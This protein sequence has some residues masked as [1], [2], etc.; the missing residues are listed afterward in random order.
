M[1]VH[2]HDRHRDHGVALLLAGL[3]TIGWTIRNWA[4]LSALRLPDTDDMVRLQQIR[5]WLAGQAFGDLAQHRLGPAPG[6]QMHWSRVPDLLPAAFIQMLSP[7]LGR[8]QAELTTVILWP[9]LLFAAALAL[10]AGI[11]RRL[12]VSGA[13][14]AVVAA[15]AYPATTLFLPGRI[16]H[17]GLQMV[18]LL[19]L[20]RAVIGRGSVTM[21][22]VAALASVTAVV[23]GLETA[24]L[25]AVAGG[26]IVIPWIGGTRA[27]EARL[28]GYGVGLVLALALAALLLRTSGWAWPA[29]DGFTGSF[30]QAA[31]IAAVAP[32]ALAAIGLRWHARRSRAVASLAAMLLAGIAA[33]AVA[34][35]CLAPYGEI[36]PLLAR[37]W[38]A[39]V[40]EAQPLFGAPLPDAIGYA[41]LMLVGTA[42]TL[43]VWH[44]TGRPAWLCLLALELAT[45]AIT[46][47]QLR[48]AYAGAL[49]AAPG[50]AALIT[51]A[52]RSGTA[53][54]VTAWLVA[55]GLLYPML[56]NVLTGWRREAP[57]PVVQAGDCTRPGD[58]ARLAALPKGVMIA[59][60]DLGAFAL[61]ATPHRV[62]AA[63]YHRNAVGNLAI[64]RFFLSPAEQARAAAEQLRAD[65]VV[66]CAGAFNELGDA[67]PA[68]ATARMLSSGHPPPWLEPLDPPDA[69]MRRFRVRR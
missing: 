47:A 16:D 21:G 46:S 30:W 67:V 44:Q 19:V 3:L 5:D 37:L 52:R 9:A 41:G 29:C 32:L 63:P 2:I 22:A 13:L 7:L 28:F 69:T 24:P 64:Y 6:L 35:G 36:D 20:V 4:D 12:D 56:G 58:L 25:L 40:A 61:A 53:T 11:A 43:R 62:I 57:G 27:A 55:A 38:L 50:L 42:A 68:S 15:L 49:L 65:Y 66:W 8:T 18:L 45:L 10:I 14:A 26:A 60:I 59:P 1:A 33:L 51:A 39:N 31:Q 54:V 48:G 23:I 17:H 34:P